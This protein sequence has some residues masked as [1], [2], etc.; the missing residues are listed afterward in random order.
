MRLTPAGVNGDL[1]QD[2]PTPAVRTR[3]GYLLLAYVATGFGIAGVFLPLLPATPFLLIAVWA[4]SRGSQRV[5]DW[6]YAQP[7]F[8]RLLNDWHEQGAV[9]LAAKWIASLMMLAS[10]ATLAL[11]GAHWGVFLGLSLFFICIA[12][13]LWTRPN[14]RGEALDEGSN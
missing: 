4:A 13:F 9:P 1:D 6:I 3:W 2:D 14:P 12:I 5:H 11:S 8:A 7:T 10:L